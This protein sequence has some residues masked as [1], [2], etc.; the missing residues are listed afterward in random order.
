VSRPAP[1]GRRG[2]EAPAALIA[3]PL[4]AALVLTLF[5]WP[6][7]R[8]EPRDLP[9]GVAG[10]PGAVRPIEQRL[11][12]ADGS[13]EVHR[14]RDEADARAAIADRDVYGAFVAGAGGARTLTASAASPAVAAA[15]TAAAE[16]P[17]VDV[18]PVPDHDQ[19]GAGLAAAT[20]PLVMAGMLAGAA[21]TFLAPAGLPRAGL[22]A[23][24]AG[25]AG[26]AA[27]AIAQAWL[28]V[29]E[30][31]WAA[32]WGAFSL[33]MVAIA[34]PAAGLAGLI[35][36]AGLAVVAALMIVVGN[37]LSG[38]AAAPELLPEPLGAV[39]Q[40]LPPGAG[41]NLLRS[42]GFFGGAGAGEH[43][44]VLFAW[45]G[46]GLA[47]LAVAGARGRRRRLSSRERASLPA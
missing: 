6:A 26:L 5:P 38:T 4:L 15:L 42:T 47:A 37:A 1:T 34:W 19:R 28:G 16:G 33:T 30:G 35:G 23:A 7:A 25:A 24:F 21:A 46:L 2:R 8:Q 36:R 43:L 39:G 18:V 40:L 14:F 32:N 3:M 31:D 13:F 45:A 10:P 17:T 11:D 9:V 22:A 20:L 44:C 29:I 27:T 12:A 41:G